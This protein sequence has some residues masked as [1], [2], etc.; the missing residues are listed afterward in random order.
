VAADAIGE[1]PDTALVRAEIGRRH[2]P[3]AIARHRH[4]VINVGLRRS[5][6]VFTQRLRP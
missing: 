1:R 2:F 3:E 6:T 4:L 5:I